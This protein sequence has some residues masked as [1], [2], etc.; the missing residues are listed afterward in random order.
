MKTFT[1]DYRIEPYC[2]PE[3]DRYFAG[4][5]PCV[6]DIETTGLT[7]GR[8]TA[9]VILTALLIPTETGIRI[10]Q[11]LAEDPYE[12]DRV[13]QATM[14]FFIDNQID[15][16][17]TYNGASF[18]LPFTNRRLEATRHPFRLDL[19]NLDFYAFLRKYS[20]LPSALDS[21]SQKSVERYFGIGSDRRDVI[22]GRESIRLYY[23]Y[24]RTSS[25][26]LEKVILT[27]N[28]EDVL[29]LYRILKIAG[30]EDFRSIL[31]EGDLHRAL[32]DF[33][34]PVRI[35][36][37]GAKKPLQQEAAAFTCPLQ[38]MPKLRR[39]SIL[40]RGR[41]F[42]APYLQQQDDEAI[43]NGPVVLNGPLRRY[44]LNAAVFPDLRND[45]TAHFRSKTADFELQLPLRSYGK[46]LYYPITHA[47]DPE[48]LNGPVAR[49]LG[50]GDLDTLINGSLIAAGDEGEA[51][52][53]E[54]NLLALLKTAR[55]YQALTSGPDTAE[56]SPSG[57]VIS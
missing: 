34:L 25:P 40:I 43:G 31:R 11:F 23:E 15:Y 56:Y 42:R 5:N 8:G 29:Q 41:Q 6:Y 7:Q 30:Y 49:A 17:I 37:V 4:L 27:H 39:D 3:F 14:Q 19:Y 53:L 46:A 18:D 38:L 48:A 45:L 20:V 36:A 13:L 22:T 50:L 55:L 57:R 26:V 54:I 47:P 2:S 44:P 24:T 12:E 51:Y 32:A 1:R 10:T 9:R 28:R 21:L 35:P 33:G 52:P 16:V